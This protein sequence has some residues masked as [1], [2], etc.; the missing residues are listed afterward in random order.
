[1]ASVIIDNKKAHK[2]KVSFQKK[3]EKDISQLITLVHHSVKFLD[4]CLPNRP[5]FFNIPNPGK[6]IMS[7]GRIK[8]FNDEILKELFQEIHESPIYKMRLIRSRLQAFIDMF[9][10]PYLDGLAR[11]LPDSM[12]SEFRSL[13]N[14]LEKEFDEQVKIFISNYPNMHTAS[15]N[16][17]VS[18]PDLYPGFTEEQM[19]FAIRNKLDKYRSNIDS[20]FL[21][22]VTHF[23]IKP[24]DMTTSESDLTEKQIQIEARN[25]VAQEAGAKLSHMVDSF[26]EEVRKDLRESAVNAFTDLLQAIKD[27]KWN[28]KSINSTIKYID[29]FKNLNF[30]NDKELEKFLSDKRKEMETVSAQEIKKNSGSSEHFKSMIE[31]SVNELKK[32]AAEE[33]KAL[34]DEFGA[35]GKRSIDPF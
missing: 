34:V 19:E 8:L 30:L 15:I 31:N 16:Y 6:S 4:P 22:S 3:D 9:T 1:M 27:D 33:K 17:F 23:D 28:Q 12:L 7:F 2:E 18:H 29:R 35:V 25:K 24:V 13:V 20:R 14:Q 11:A 5:E 32:M 26:K 21:F 10:F